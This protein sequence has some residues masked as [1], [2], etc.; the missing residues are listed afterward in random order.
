MSSET[1]EELQVAL[2]VLMDSRRSSEQT[3]WALAVLEAMGPRVPMRGFTPVLTLPT[4]HAGYRE[5][6]EQKARS[7][8]A[9]GGSTRQ[10]SETYTHSRALKKL[11]EGWRRYRSLSKSR[12]GSKLT[13]V[14][15]STSAPYW[16]LEIFF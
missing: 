6:H 9:S 2:D 4:P 13:T 5:A 8:S 1:S 16:N 7:F 12:G 10:V 11:E 3:S 15:T 14:S